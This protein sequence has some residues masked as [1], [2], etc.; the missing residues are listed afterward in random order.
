MASQGA[1]LQAITNELVKSIED[2]K[3]RQEVLRN[4]ILDEEDEKD[5]VERELSV[6]ADRLEKINGRYSTL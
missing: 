2:M 1:T 5:R 4:Q 6:L 3:E